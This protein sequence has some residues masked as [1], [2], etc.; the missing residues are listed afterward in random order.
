MLDFFMQNVLNPTEA[1]LAG[2]VV[3]TNSANI[4]KFYST[5]PK[6]KTV[7]IS[8]NFVESIDHLGKLDIFAGSSCGAIW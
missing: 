7:K 2:V 5:H 4:K 6:Y 1:L 8:D 3:L